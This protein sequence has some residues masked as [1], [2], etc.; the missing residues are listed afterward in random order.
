MAY[1]ERLQQN[2]TDL[3]EILADLDQLPNMPVPNPPAVYQNLEVTENGTYTAGAGYDAIGQVTVDVASGVVPKE[4][5]SITLNN[6]TGHHGLM[7]V[8]IDNSFVLST[9]S[10]SE[11]TVTIE[12]YGGFFGNVLCNGGIAYPHELP[13]NC[14]RF[15]DGLWFQVFE[16]NL[17]INFTGGGGG[18]GG[19]AG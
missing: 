12:A 17:V 13:K 10:F 6:Q 15:G 2:N 1:K 11:D 16:D 3:N 7:V 19:D 9:H 4:K 18:G 8:Y 5:Y 14:F